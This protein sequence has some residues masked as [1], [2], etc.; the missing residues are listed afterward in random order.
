MEASGQH[1]APTASDL[2][3]NPLNSRLGGPQRRR[4]CCRINSLALLTLKPRPVQH[5]VWALKRQLYAGSP[6]A[7]AAVA[8]NKVKSL[9]T[10]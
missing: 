3:K 8:V 5:V 2:G 1:H 4:F 7:A 9:S 6:A 10:S